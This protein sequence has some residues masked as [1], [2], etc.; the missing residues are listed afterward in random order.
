MS[1]QQKTESVVRQLVQSHFET[2]TSID[3]IIW[4]LDGENQE[5]HLIEINRET[6]PSGSVEVLYFSS[7]PDVPFPLRI[8][9]VTPQEWQRIQAGD[10]S[11][12]A[13]WSLGKMKR[14]ARSKA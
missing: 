1:N 14:F 5:I 8:A 6:F 2:E 3:E 10:I 13:G 9:D 12:P 11:L 4:F 7:T